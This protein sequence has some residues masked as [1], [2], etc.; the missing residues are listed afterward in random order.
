MPEADDT[1]RGSARGAV[2]RG[3]S[4]I[5]TRG[6]RSATTRSTVLLAR[7]DLRRDPLPYVPI[8][9]VTV[10]EDMSAAAGWGGR[11][12]SIRL[13]GYSWEIP[14]RR[15][16]RRVTAGDGKAL[17]AGRGPGLRGRQRPRAVPVHALGLGA[18]PGG[19]HLP[20]DDLPAGTWPASPEPTED[21]ALRWATLERGPASVLHAWRDPRPHDHRR[22]HPLCIGAGPQERRRAPANRAIQ[23]PSTRRQTVSR[24]VSL[25]ILPQAV[26]DE[27]RT[28]AGGVGTRSP[29]PRVDRIVGAIGRGGL[30]R[31]GIDGRLRLA[32]PELRLGRFMRPGRCWAQQVSLGGALGRRLLRGGGLGAAVDDLPRD[33]AQGRGD[34]RGHD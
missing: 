22:R 26:G 23:R 7:R 30:T 1:R 32:V 21:L 16:A 18:R 27:P 17:G 3:T 8:G 14:R 10:G 9:V 11:I 15:P 19:R 6:S 28:V 33:P 5:R 13:H 20:R 2:G 4:H 12:T 34:D 25:A 31:A 24:R 29:T